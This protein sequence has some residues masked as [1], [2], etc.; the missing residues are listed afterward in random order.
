MA[1]MSTRGPTKRFL[2]SEM[3]RSVK[4]MLK[5]IEDDG[6][7][8]AK[9][10]EI[11]IQKRPE[12]V[13]QVEDFY[14][15]FRSL[16]ERYDDATCELRRTL[17]SDSRSQACGMNDFRSE[18][19]SAITSP[20]NKLHRRLSVTNSAF[21]DVVGN[22]DYET[23]AYDS[24]SDLDD[25]FC[26]NYSG[27]SNYDNYRRLRHKI[28]EL[29]SELRKLQIEQEVNGS[30]TETAEEL[31]ISKEKIRSSEE[32][33]CNLKTKLEKYESL[34]YDDKFTDESV[35]RSNPETV[36]YDEEL[37]VAKQKI[38]S[39][40][41][42]ICCLR[43]KLEKYESL[44]CGDTFLNESVNMINTME[45]EDVKKLM[46]EHDL[47]GENADDLMY[48]T[49]IKDEIE[50]LKSERDE[51]VMKLN[52]LEEEIRLKDDQID[53]LNDRLEKLQLECEKSKESIEELEKVIEKQRAMIEEEAEE[54][55][56]TEKQLCIS[57]EHYRNAYQMLRKGL[58]E[59]KNPVMAS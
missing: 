1:K 35:N 51:F 15:M 3:D 53:E 11:Y 46:Q 52:E 30:N 23:P 37:R 12:L 7:S 27:T 22:K 55:Q 6:D 43:T 32:E 45:L 49:E 13:S 5:L 14:R 19:P 28:T 38:R 36:D 33:I 39:S 41:E 21:L 8:F 29:E 50:Q 44:Q 59:Q 57:L 34:R 40:E 54:K 47:E 18:P 58:L 26:N 48:E 10:A 4:R 9:K 24:G 25:S 31:R 42:E 20:E 56:E 17:P 16:A 2:I